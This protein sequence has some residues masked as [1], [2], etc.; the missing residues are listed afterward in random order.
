[1]LKDHNSNQITLKFTQEFNREM[2]YA[3]DSDKYRN[4]QTIRGKKDRMGLALL[5][6][7]G[8]RRNRCT[9]CGEWKLGHTCLK[10]GTAAVSNTASKN[11]MENDDVWKELL[12]PED[13]V[14]D[15]FWSASTICGDQG[16]CNF[17]FRA[18][19]DHTP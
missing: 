1:M 11:D 6:E 2:G 18:F 4:K 7:P 10:A 15:A 16:V 17:D 13:T 19:M 5:R 12:M 14:E 3:D 9:L 8:A